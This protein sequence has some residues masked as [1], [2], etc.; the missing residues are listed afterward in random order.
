M[1]AQPP[2]EDRERR[3]STPTIH[4]QTLYPVRT[5]SVG[6]FFSA[7]VIF[8]RDPACPPTDEDIIIVTVRLSRKQRRNSFDD[9][10][11]DRYVCFPYLWKFTCCLREASMPISNCLYSITR[12]A[13]TPIFRS[14]P[15]RGFLRRMST[16]VL[17]QPSPDRYKAV[18]MPRGDYVRYFR[19]NA[20][21]H[22]VGTEPERE[23]GE[24]EIMEKYGQYQDLP[25]RSI[26]GRTTGH[27]APL[28]LAWG[29]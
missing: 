29:T 1:P 12:Y 2:S 11:P 28:P 18:K 21:G 10:L 5:R 27:D 14:P 20:Q 15:A 26:L 25:L 3:G 4:H 17:T 6:G 13:L 8:E 7:N 22:Y 16:R 24:E 9:P 19:H 23:W